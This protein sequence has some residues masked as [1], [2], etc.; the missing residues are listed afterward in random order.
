MAL[1]KT[2]EKQQNLLEKATG[3]AVISGNNKNKKPKNA[4]IERALAFGMNQPSPEEEEAENCFTLKLT[5][6][7]ENK[8]DKLCEFLGLSWGNLLNVAVRYS[9]FYAETKK[10]SLSQL[11]ADPKHLGCIDLAVE[12][13][14]ETTSKLPKDGMKEIVAKCA[15]FG[16]ETLYANLIENI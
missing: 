2:K 10:V 12:L 3:E 14:V 1:E 13:N 9:V 4:V 7:L 16:I 5:E 8:L 6:S 15:V 11:A